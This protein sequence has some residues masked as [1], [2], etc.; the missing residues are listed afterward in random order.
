[1]YYNNI[2]T[3]YQ[4]VRQTP[5]LRDRPPCRR[6]EC[7]H[8]WC[9]HL[10]F[11]TELLE[12]QRQTAEAILCARLSR[13]THRHIVHFLAASYYQQV[14]HGSREG[15]EWGR[16]A[17]SPDSCPPGFIRRLAGADGGPETGPKQGRS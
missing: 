3:Y 11:S 15:K 16:T 14:T 9:N 6:H 8:L 17:P 1:I 5:P 2:N 7:L 12:G 13:D 4:W 10:R